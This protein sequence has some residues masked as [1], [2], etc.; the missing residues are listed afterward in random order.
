MNTP[1]YTGRRL[2]KTPSGVRA[3]SPPTPDEARRAG[4]KSQAAPSDA[5]RRGG[6]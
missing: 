1:I 2:N 4:R 3:T 6:G 5:S